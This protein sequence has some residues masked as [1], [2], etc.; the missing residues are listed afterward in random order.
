MKRLKKIILLFFGVSACSTPSNK[1]IEGSEQGFS[2]L[3]YGGELLKIESSN[4]DRFILIKNT[5]IDVCKSSI[6]E[7]CE[8]NVSEEDKN[9]SE[10]Y[11][12]HRFKLCEQGSWLIVNVSEEFSFY[13]FHNLVGWM[14][15]S[16]QTYGFSIHKVSPNK[17]YYVE[18]DRTDNWGDVLVGSDQNENSLYTYLPDAYVDGG[19]LRLTSEIKYSYANALAQL[20]SARIDLSSVSFIWEPFDVKLFY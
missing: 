19:N 5:S 12:E 7:Y 9:S 13:N 2:D 17:S 11:D 18:L 10:N 15:D 1:E 3:K 20:D 8:L 6:I 4:F 16:E 14:H